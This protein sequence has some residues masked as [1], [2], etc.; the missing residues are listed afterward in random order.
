MDLLIYGLAYIRM[1]VKH[2]HATTD[3]PREAK[4]QRRAQ[5][6]TDGSHWKGETEQI[7]GWTGSE[8]GWEQVRG[9]GRRV[10]GETPGIGDHFGGDVKT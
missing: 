10:L 9:W 2:N 6:G 4:Q 1:A 3:R 5:H 8:W 7:S